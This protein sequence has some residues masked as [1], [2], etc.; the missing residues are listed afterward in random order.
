M[1]EKILNTADQWLIVLLPTQN[2]P[3]SKPDMVTGHLD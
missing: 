3:G 1:N 2:I